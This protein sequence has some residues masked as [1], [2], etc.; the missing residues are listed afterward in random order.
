M[1]LY[2]ATDGMNWRK[3]KNWGTKAPL[4]DWQGVTVDA[5]GDVIELDLGYNNLRGG[6]WVKDKQH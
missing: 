5:K 1:D 4:G 6:E 2:E 3:A